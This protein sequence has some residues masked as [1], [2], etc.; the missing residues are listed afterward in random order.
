MSTIFKHSLGKSRGTD[1]PHEK[2]DFSFDHEQRGLGGSQ[3]QIP[4]QLNC[5]VL[6]A[7]GLR[8]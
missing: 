8:L 3:I 1:L 5:R 4:A 6:A 7:L 2:K